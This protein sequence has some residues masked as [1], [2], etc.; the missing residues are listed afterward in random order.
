MN[1]EPIYAALYAK[2]AAIAG[3]R[4]TSRVLKHW[5]DVQPEQQPALFMAQAREVPTTTTGQPSKWDL[6]VDVYVYARTGGSQVPGT[7]I[8]PIL[9]AIEAALPLHPVTGKHMLDAPGVEWAR[10]DGTIETDEGTLGDQMVA[11]VPI[12]ILAT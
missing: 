8:N 7:V 4:T 3:L 9:D 10:I 11:I 12:H 6:F 1:R 2:L 5:N